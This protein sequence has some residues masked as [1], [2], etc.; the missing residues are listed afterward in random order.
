MCFVRVMIQSYI[1][2]LLDAALKLPLDIIYRCI[3][4]NMYMC[5]CAIFLLYIA[6]MSRPVG[7]MTGVNGSAA[8]MKSANNVSYCNY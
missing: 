8:V 7:L 1:S 6:C 4:K 3:L 2:S 5:A